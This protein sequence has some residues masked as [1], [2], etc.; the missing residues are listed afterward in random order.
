M[1]ADALA[2]SIF[3]K[4]TLQDCSLEELQHVATQY[5]Y[6]AAVQL[7]LAKK[8][9]T[10]NEDLYLQQLQKLS[11]YINDPLWLDF[12][13]N[14]YQTN[15][16]NTRQNEDASLLSQPGTSEHRDDDAHHERHLRTSEAELVGTVTHPGQEQNVMEPFDQNETITESRGLQEEF[17]IKQND[18]EGREKVVSEIST[19]E[20]SKISTDVSVQSHSDE[21]GTSFMNED[22]TVHQDERETRADEPSHGDPSTVTESTGAEITF[23]P[24]HTI[25]YFASQG[26]KFIPEERPADR[27]AQQL[28]S[29]TEWLKT[30]KRLPQTEVA[31]ISE[32]PNDE[33]VQEMADHSINESDVVT[34][35]M[36]EVWLKQGNKE[37]A[38]EIYDK[39][40]LLN[41]A[42]S[43]YFASLS[44][45][46]KNA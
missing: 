42:K 32:Q 31:K 21:N 39:L 11:V 36:A 25:D 37:K 46:L 22:D 5:P 3:Q 16:V 8:L 35:A 15:S 20:D 9:K 34:E 4:E 12:L 23:T 38:I 10:T 14:G 13:L 18:T 41:P 28:K 29:F 6:F 30:M 45:Q 43:A 2:K 40:S 33:K 7:L 17:S 1:N 26:I 19:P 27:F 24:Y 44:Q